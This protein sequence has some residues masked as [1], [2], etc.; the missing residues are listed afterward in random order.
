[1]IPVMNVQR[2]YASLQDELDKAALEVL[3][4]GGYILGPKVADFEQQ[5]ADYCGAKYSVGVG[6]G[7]EALVIAL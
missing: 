6:N 5:F 4:S 3:H 7:T 2:Q 1:M